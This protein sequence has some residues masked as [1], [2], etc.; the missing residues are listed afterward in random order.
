MRGGKKGDK[1][2]ETAQGKDKTLGPRAADKKRE[3]LAAS[4][5][6]CTHAFCCGS[7]YMWPRAEGGSSLSDLVDSHRSTYSWSRALLQH[8]ARD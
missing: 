6:L 8:G 2:E 3:S 7:N 1:V 5:P 4:S